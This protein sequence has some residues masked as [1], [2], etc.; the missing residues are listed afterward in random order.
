MSSL[1]QRRQ[2]VLV[3]DIGGTKTIAAVVRGRDLLAAQTFP[4]DT[5]DAARHFA[6]C[7]AL[8]DPLCDKAGIGRSAIAACGV[9]LP[10]MVD[11]GNGRLL[12]APLAGWRDVPARAFFADRLGLPPERVAVENDVNACALGEHGY[13]ADPC[14]DFLWLTVSTGCGGAVFAEGRLLRGAGG[15]AGEI[16]HVKVEYT[17]PLLCPCGQSGCLEAHASGTAMAAQLAADPVL[18]DRCA[19]RGLAPTAQSLCLL[20]S[21]GDRN[22]LRITDRCGVWLGRAIAAALNLV[23]AR[24]VYIGGGVAQSLALFLPAIRRT[25]AACTVAG[26]AD[27]ELLPSALGYQAAVFGAAATAYALEDA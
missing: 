11:T 17:R 9:N 21:E 25:V 3:Y 12:Y 19:A 7:A 5:A 16:G 13:A 1:A 22:A 15:C 24:R 4:T 2:P 20:A 8:R 14:R 27:A 23:N 26:C 18:A 10:G 6:V